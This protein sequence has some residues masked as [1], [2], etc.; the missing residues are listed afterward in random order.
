MSGGQPAARGIIVGRLLVSAVVVTAAL[1]SDEISV[2]P[3][4][5]LGI[6][7]AAVSIPYAVWSRR[8]GRQS[9]GL[10]VALFVADVVLVTLL[11][12]SSGGL[13]SPFKLLYF[14]PV[15]V[16][17]TALGPKPGAIVTVTSLA[18]FAVLFVIETPSA[19]R[20]HGAGVLAETLVLAVALTVVSVL[21]GILSRRVREGE[22][23]LGEVES[24]LDAAHVHIDNLIESMQSGLALF[25][26]SGGLLSL[27]ERGRDILAIEA[28]EAARTHFEIVFAERPAFAEHV[29]AALDEGAT[30]ERGE[31]S[32]E[33][34][35]GSLPVGLSTSL[36]R[37]DEGVAAGVIVIFQDLTEARRRELE[38]LH[39][40][41]LASLGGFAAGVAHEIRNPLNAIKGSAE[42]LRDGVE[43]G[44]DDAKLVDLII[45]ESDRLA[46]LTNDVLT[47]GRVV[48]PPN[49]VVLMDSLLSE[50]EAIARS[51]RSCG[52]GL[53]LSVSGGGR[54]VRGNA[55]QLK[56]VLLNLVVNAMEA[57][58]GEGSVRVTTDAGERV[59][60]SGRTGT[61]GQVAVVVEDDGVGMDAATREEMLAPFWTT[62]QS[63][64]GLG[65]AIVDKLVE[66]HGGR[67]EIE[68]E[69]GRGSR[70]VIY[71]NEASD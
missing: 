35:G 8:S 30:T 39:A 9:L 60:A 71:L 10:L 45:R 27:N 21:V 57:V 18:A 13:S 49:G 52:A 37:D 54:R 4:V 23:R 67:L 22:K 66:V 12:L 44:S 43:A 40:D 56:Q 19:V 50:V 59:S 28:P 65:L 51:H 62:K 34:P 46:V 6:G 69:P 29:R 24:A 25:D 33:R 55:E 5:L 48:D 61:D 36:L 2:T 38:R 17:S 41:R 68:S 7:V 16:S 3:V 11:V 70:F 64:T 58:E 15:I 26:M 1:L 53:A 47:Y 32:I 20:S 42:M 63:G 14:L 31:I